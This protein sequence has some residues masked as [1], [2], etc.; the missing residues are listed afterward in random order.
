M[1]LFR[2]NVTNLF[3][4]PR[5]NTTSRFLDFIGQTWLT[6]FLRNCN[7]FFRS[8]WP[9]R[10]LLVL[11][12]L[13]FSF[14]YRILLFRSWLWMMK[15]GCMHPKSTTYQPYMVE[16]MTWF[17]AWDYSKNQRFSAAL[18]QYHR[19]NPWE[20]FD[21]RKLSSL[22][23]KRFILHRVD[24]DFVSVIISFL[25]MNQFKQHMSGAYSHGTSASLR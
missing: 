7:F 22:F 4:F 12:L 5:S 9:R 20:E 24:H 2:A 21:F 10:E 23:G 8:V 15:I 17:H 13:S 18:W 16:F 14:G 19:F 11:I 25:L 6:N 3:F 1:F